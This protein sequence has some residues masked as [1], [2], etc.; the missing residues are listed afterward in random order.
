MKQYKIRIDLAI[1][2]IAQKSMFHLR[3]LE[4][5]YIN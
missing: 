5:Y 2:N 1:I 3:S 4:W